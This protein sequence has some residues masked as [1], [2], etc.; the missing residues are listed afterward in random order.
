MG[1][2]V[3]AVLLGFGLLAAAAS[4]AGRPIASASP[5]ESGV[6]ESR[7]FRSSRILSTS[8]S[9][10]ALLLTAGLGIWAVQLSYHFSSD[11]EESID[12]MGRAVLG[13]AIPLPHPKGYKRITD[14]DA[15]DAN[16]KDA[17]SLIKNGRLKLAEASLNTA[18]SLSFLSDDVIIRAYLGLAFAT[19]GDDTTKRG[20]TAKG[21]SLQRRALVQ[22]DYALGNKKALGIKHTL[23]VKSLRWWARIKLNQIGKMPQQAKVARAVL[24]VVALAYLI[25]GGYE[26]YSLRRRRRHKKT[27]KKA[28]QGKSDG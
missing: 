17:D 18:E 3:T 27:R 2:G 15:L 19:L 9:L 20:D 1:A 25:W 21:L 16:L 14:D 26:L 24:V 28:E 5:P 8:L 11:S 13:S 22:Y 7:E 10:F 12:L 23:W 6:A 4:A